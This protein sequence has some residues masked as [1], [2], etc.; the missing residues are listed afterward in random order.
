[1]NH[2]EDESIVM[3]AGEAWM[4]DNLNIHSVE[5]NGATERITAIICMRVE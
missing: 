5:N 4:F 3:Q 2:C 1:V